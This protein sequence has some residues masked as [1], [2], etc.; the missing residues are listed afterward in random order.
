MIIK[1]QCP[2]EKMLHSPHSSVSWKKHTTA[3]FSTFFGLVIRLGPCDSQVWTEAIEASVTEPHSP[4]SPAMD[5]V[6]DNQS[7]VRLA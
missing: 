5:S 3:M 6:G 4:L 1:S 2:I 7:S